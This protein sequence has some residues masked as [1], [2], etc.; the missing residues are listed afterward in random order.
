MMRAETGSVRG[1]I[2][3]RPGMCGMRR[4][5]V[6]SIYTQGNSAVHGDSQPDGGGCLWQQPFGITKFK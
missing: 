6:M 3:S 5:N 4:G 1:P 2:G